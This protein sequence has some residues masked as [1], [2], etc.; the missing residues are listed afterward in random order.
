MAAFIHDL[1]N[2]A[3]IKVSLNTTAATTGTTNGVSCD[4]LQ[5]D[6]QC[7]GVFVA[8]TATGNAPSNAVKLQE[9]TDNT[10][11]TDISGATFTTATTNATYQTISFVRTARYVRSYSTISGTGSLA[12]PSMVMLGEQTKYVA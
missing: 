8:S 4:F 10:T 2:N 3:T 11:W 6:G 12:C 9:S 5:G 1:V 7:F